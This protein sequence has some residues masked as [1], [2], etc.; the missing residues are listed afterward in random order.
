MY[1]KVKGDEDVED[2]EDEEDGV[3]MGMDAGRKPKQQKR[4]GKARG[5]GKAAGDAASAQGTKD[6]T[7]GPK[8]ITSGLRARAF[9]WYHVCYHPAEVQRVEREAQDHGFPAAPLFLSFAWIGVDILCSSLSVG[10]PAAGSAAS[11]A[12]GAE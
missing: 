12:A 4:R 2:D 10:E 7:E 3:A 9:A 6:A 1:R 8:F 11:H 5:G